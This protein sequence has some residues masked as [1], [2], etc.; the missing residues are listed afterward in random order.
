MFYADSILKDPQVI[1]VQKQLYDS[2]HTLEYL[3]PFNLIIS[4]L[5]V[6]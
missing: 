1:G 2:A 4:D 3:F 6:A 5:T